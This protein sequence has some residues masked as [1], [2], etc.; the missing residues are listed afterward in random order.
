M[1][2]SIFKATMDY[3]D[4]I[5]HKFDDGSIRLADPRILAAKKSQKYNLRSDEAMKSDNREDFMKAMEKEL[6]YLTTK[7]VW[8][9]LPKSSLPTSAHIIR[10]I[11][12][13]RKKKNVW[14]S[15]QTQGFFMC[16]WWYSTRRD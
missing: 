14:I 12:S 6:K 8:G 3:T 16:T 1:N 15:N 2:V 5:S 7:Y 13:F 4:L 11:Q 9:I 10:F